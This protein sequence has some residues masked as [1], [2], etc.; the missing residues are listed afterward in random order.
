M[1][2]YVMLCRVM[3]CY[4]M[5]GNVIWC[6]VMSGNVMTCHVMSCYVMLCHVMSCYVMSYYVMSGNVMSRY[7]MS[8][9]VIWC[10][11]MSCQVISNVYGWICPSIPVNRHKCCLAMAKKKIF[12]YSR[13]SVHV[14]FEME[15]RQKSGF[16][17]CLRLWRDFFFQC[18][19]YLIHF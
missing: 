6:H 2:C 5:S 17:A 16:Y 14:L 8:V 12:L 19:I 1:S 15:K 10:H 13:K 18:K 3:S 4:V 7:V 11:V 9:N